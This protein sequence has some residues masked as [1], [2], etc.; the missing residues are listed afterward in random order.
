[1]PEQTNPDGVIVSELLADRTAGFD[2]LYRA[3]ADRLFGYAVSLVKDRE[4]AADVV[5]ESL[6]KAV[7]NIGK[8]RDP[9]KLRPWVFA[10][11]RNESM[12]ALRAGNRWTDDEEAIDMLSVDADVDRA[13]ESQDAQ[14]LVRDAMEALS[15]ADRDTLALALRN[16]LDAQEVAL[17]MGANANTA[18]A[19]ISRAKAALTGAVT[20][21]VLTRSERN[22]CPGLAEALHGF[23]G[24]LSPLMRKR[25]SRHVQDC[26]QCEERGQKRAMAYVSAFTLPAA[27]VLPAGFQAKAAAAVQSMSSSGVIPDLGVIDANGFPVAGENAAPLP[28]ASG[29]DTVTLQTQVSQDAPTADVPLW[30][31]PADSDEPAGIDPASSSTR[32]AWLIGAGVAA[33]VAMI[34]GGALLL[35]AGNSQDPDGGPTPTAPA[36]TGSAQPTTS[37]TSQQTTSTPTPTPTRSTPT[38][39]RTTQTPTQSPT[40]TPTPTPT[41]TT[42]PTATR[43]SNPKPSG[44]TNS[45]NSGRASQNPAPAPDAS[46]SKPKDPNTKSPPVSQS[47]PKRPDPVNITLATP[48]ASDTNK[49][50]KVVWSISATT[51]GEA[52]SVKVSYRGPES[53]VRSLSSQGNGSWGAQMTLEE[54][55]Y[56]F[57]AVASDSRGDQVS[58][59]PRKGN[60]FCSK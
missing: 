11:T 25:V 16:D 10:I 15:P 44:T 14:A 45:G 34:I 20:A 18:R 60:F 31:E 41:G 26:D 23:E 8:L 35:Q 56:E 30:T 46:S 48:G 53:G 55:T 47:E 51:T 2:A 27:L 42:T 37:P 49:C 19:K 22:N 6:L 7:A 33:V 36:P 32:R 28:D 1:M 58:S 50:P 13:V 52:Q 12:S 40:T 57:Q 39:T 5:H 29:M 17:A 54:G 21:L 4:T 38:P 9:S 24:F 43:T 3:Y 59:S